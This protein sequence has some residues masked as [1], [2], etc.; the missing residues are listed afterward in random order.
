VNIEISSIKNHIVKP[1]FT[2]IRITEEDISDVI[3]FL[4]KE[5]LSDYYRQF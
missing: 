3:E 1:D 5:A 4:A 2:N